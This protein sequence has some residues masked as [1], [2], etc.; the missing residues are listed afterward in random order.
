M[1]TRRIKHTKQIAKEVKELIKDFLKGR[2]L[3][4]SDEKT[5]IT[6]IDNV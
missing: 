1:I 5:V 2:G 6:H 4:L 3:E